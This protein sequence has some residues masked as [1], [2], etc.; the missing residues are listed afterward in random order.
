MR[1][2]ILILAIAAFA[3]ILS[4]AS[5]AQALVITPTFT[6]AFA[7]DFGV[8][9]ENA[10]I[11]AANVYT[12]NFTDPIHIN[13]TVDAVAGTGVFGQSQS[14]LVGSNF[15]IMQAALVAD[16]KSA[17][18]HTAVGPGGSASGA[19]PTG[20]AGTFW[21]TTAEGKALGLI[22]DSTANVDGIT[23]F[24]AGFNWDFTGNTP[25]SNAF[26]FQ[27]V[28]A[29]EISEVMG[30]IGLKGGN[31]GGFAP[32]YSVLDLF[33]YTGPGSRSLAGGANAFFSIDAGNSLLKEYNNYLVNGLDSR[34]WAPGTNDAF[35]QFSDPGV[36]NAVSATDIREL[37]VIGYDL[38]TS[39][40]ATP[41]PATLSLWGLG[42]AI[43]VFA[44]RRSQRKS[45]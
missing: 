23:T 19:D 35:N 20:G 38:K 11:A 30:R 7:T 43:S 22:A 24:G 27:G 16:A 5:Q 36:V 21:A 40:G 32:S 6:A 3:A 28:A 33:S 42:V 39:G 25:A 14:A 37:D 15:A 10:W 18:D 8:S 1:N 13:I 17:D 26:D 29:H 4:A 41:E 2:R 9:G 45:N 44:R 31:I 34:D 12:S